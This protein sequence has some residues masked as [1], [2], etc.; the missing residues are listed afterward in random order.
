MLFLV[1]IIFI[2]IIYPKGD[3]ATQLKNNNVPAIGYVLIE[4]GVMTESK[5]IGAL[6]TGIEAPQD[7]IFNVASVTKP[8]FAT[9]VMKL[10][11]DGLIDLDEP[12]Y[13]YWIDPDI[14]AD[15]RH[16]KLTARMLL[17]H[18]SGFPNWRWFNEDGKLSFWFEPGTTY[19]YSGEGMEYLKKAIENKSERSLLQLMD[20]II[21]EPVDM[22]DTRMIWD[23]LLH[24]K[25]L[26][27]FHNRQ[28]ELY[29]IR[30]R[31]NPVAS[32]DLCT[33][34]DDLAKFALYILNQKGGLS[35]T[36]YNQ[37]V[38]INT[39]MTER[40]GYGLGWQVVPNLPNGEYALVHGGS[41]EGV[42][43]RIVILPKSKS[44]FIAFV[45]GDNGQ[46][47]IDRLMV[48]RLKH[49]DTILSKIYSPVIWRIIHL[50][51]NIL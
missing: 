12:L 19:H 44:A 23:S 30:K 26:A 39:E 46:Q 4:N 42:R 43:A 1:G 41:D 14:Q 50:P 49:G 13:P 51:F 22:K 33:T 18:K 20:S 5:V 34:T 38:T 6:E 21:F 47:I 11:D 28:G 3:L 36:A 40:S 25:K 2:L 10:V 48:K 27:K 45:N 15:D 31:T 37:M 8:V 35:D 7:A 32:D 29:E 24:E 17:S 9:M 16:K